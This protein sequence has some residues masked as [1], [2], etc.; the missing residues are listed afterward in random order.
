MILA[1]QKVTVSEDVGAQV[2]QA[3]NGW[4]SEAI[5]AEPSMSVVFNDLPKEERAHDLNPEEP[6][7]IT[8]PTSAYMPQSNELP[9]ERKANLWPPAAEP[10][11]LDQEF[12]QKEVA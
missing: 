3:L 10:Q 7:L 9:V 2:S 4:A 5:A 1:E 6:L 8:S 11:I 12:S